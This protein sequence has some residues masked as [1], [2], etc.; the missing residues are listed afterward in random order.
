MYAVGTSQ[1]IKSAACRV[2]EMHGKTPC[3]LWYLEGY[4][5]FIG[6]EFKEKLCLYFMLHEIPVL[7]YLFF[8]RYLVD[9]L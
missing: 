3:L 5:S 6:Y 2:L 4:L 1:V 8:S 7:I 9:T